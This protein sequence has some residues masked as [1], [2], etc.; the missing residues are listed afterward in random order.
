M[1]VS[2][3]ARMEVSA[4]RGASEVIGL[5][6]CCK[7][8]AFY[9][10]GCT[11]SPEVRKIQEI[12]ANQQFHCN[13]E[14]LL[15]TPLENIS[16]PFLNSFHQDRPALQRIF[17]LSLKR[18]TFFRTDFLSSKPTIFTRHFDHCL[19]RNFVTERG[20]REAS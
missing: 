4:T 19:I 6:R 11:L 15:E 10:F 8:W 2:C 20:L 12:D 16:Q 17:F 3:D 18:S 13:D 9:H 1:S 7:E 14:V 5:T